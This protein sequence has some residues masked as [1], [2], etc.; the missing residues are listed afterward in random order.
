[1]REIIDRVL[2]PSLITVL[3]A[4]DVVGL[5]VVRVE[6]DDLVEIGH[7]FFVVSQRMVG[8]GSVL[9][10][11]VIF[12]IFFNGDAIFIDGTLV[13]LLVVELISF[14][15]MRVNGLSLASAPYSV[16]H[17]FKIK[18]S[19]QTTLSHTSTFL[20]TSYQQRSSACIPGTIGSTVN[21]ITVK[22]SSYLL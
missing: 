18:V 9:V 5:V 10:A 4:P 14:D 16:S 15:E 3:L 2:D 20:L 17:V 7:S 1:M 8:S 22:I 11:M 12:G 19:Y 6:F 21:K 13:I